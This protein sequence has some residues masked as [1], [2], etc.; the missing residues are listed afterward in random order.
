MVK[1]FCVI[2]FLLASC[3]DRSVTKSST[4]VEDGSASELEDIYLKNGVSH[5]RVHHESLVAR[6]GYS[7]NS[8]ITISA[9]EGVFYLAEKYP[10][11]LHITASLE[12]SEL[13]EV[14]TRLVYCEHCQTE[15]M[16]EWNRME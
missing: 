14:P 16:R 8:G 3:A 2:A 1:V 11:M 12:K 5:C 9:G 10:N 15:S 4:K 13:C 6:E 7:A